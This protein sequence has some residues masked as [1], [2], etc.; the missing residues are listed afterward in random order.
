MKKIRKI[1]PLSTCDIPGIERWLEEQANDGLFPVSVGSWVTFTPDGVPGTRFRLEPYGKSGTEPTEEQLELYH[2][3]GWEYALTVGSVYFLFYTTDPAAVD[4]YSDNES[5]GLSLE[6]LENAAQRAKRRKFII[7]SVLAVALIWAVFFFKSNYDIQPDNLARL[8]LL[9]LG[10][11]NPVFSTFIVG[12]VFVWRQNSRDYQMLRKTCRALKEG[13]TPPPSPGPSKKIVGENILSLVM[14]VP[15]L[16]LLL[17]Q[18]LN[19]HSPMKNLP[20]DDFDRPYVAIQSLEET[21][22]YQWEELF[23]DPPFRDEPGTYYANISFSLLSLTWYSVTQDAYSPQNGECGN[24]FSPDPENGANRYSPDLDMTYF[25]LLI[26]AIARPV[27]EA[28]LDEYRLVNLR[29]N[30]KEVDYADLDFAILADAKDNLWQ[31]AALGKDGQ[32]AVFR[33]AGVERLSDH[34]EQLA[35]MIK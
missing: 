15:L 12:Q 33:Y 9:L 27:A 35:S 32:V 7:Y 17:G 19:W 5:R 29:W 11:F 6:R 25:K 18:W 21:P 16:I 34:L 2:S 31:M 26:P 23:E 28:Q 10:V 4:F 13:M 1:L 24:V 3:A 8:P 22:V 30:Y 14:I 20:L